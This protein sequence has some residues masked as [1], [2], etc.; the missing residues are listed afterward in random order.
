MSSSQKEMQSVTAA[1][2]F[3]GGSSALANSPDIPELLLKHHLCFPLYSASKEVVRRYTPL[4]K[5][6]N[7]TYTQYIAMMALWEHES[8]DVKTLGERLFLDS[9]TL[10]P[11]LKKLEEKSLVL[12]QK[13]NKD[14]RQLIVSLTQKGKDLRRE[15][16]IVPHQIGSCV[17]LST[18]EGAELKRL[19]L[20]V[21]SNVTES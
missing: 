6:F 19:L 17:N 14:G 8:L 10:T 18:E 3:A 12:R 9:G 5:P 7:L 20:K 2:T 13:T 15:M 11:L 4:L 1:S 21:L 16:Q